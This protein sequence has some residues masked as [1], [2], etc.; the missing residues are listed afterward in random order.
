MRI[1]HS[2][3]GETTVQNEPNEVQLTHSGSVQVKEVRKMSAKDQFAY[4]MALKGY[5][6][7]LKKHAKDIEELQE[8][9]P[10]WKPEFRWPIAQ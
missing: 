8:F 6:R 3:F 5:Q 7:A 9:F 2:N 4:E 10:G 1:V